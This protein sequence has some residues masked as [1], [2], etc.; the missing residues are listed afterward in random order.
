MCGLL[1][2]TT[3]GYEVFS[4]Q[5]KMKDVVILGLACAVRLTIKFCKDSNP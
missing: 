3:C 2:T 5:T 1:H 4:V